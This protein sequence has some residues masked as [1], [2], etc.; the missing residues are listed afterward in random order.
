MSRA[1]VC[2]VGLGFVALGMYLVMGRSVS[3]IT[4]RCVCVCVCVSHPTDTKTDRR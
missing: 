4:G 1:E 3:V 2:A